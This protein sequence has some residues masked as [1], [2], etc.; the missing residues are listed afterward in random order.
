MNQTVRIVGN[1]VRDEEEV[2]R[3]RIARVA[4]ASKMNSFWKM[5]QTDRDESSDVL[6]WGIPA[7]NRWTLASLMPVVD[8]VWV[9][10]VV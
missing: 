7:Q 10:G 9:E 5:Y 8:A 2:T 4:N 6:V 1:V 3:R